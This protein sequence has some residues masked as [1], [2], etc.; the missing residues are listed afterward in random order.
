MCFFRHARP[1]SLGVL[2]SLPIASLSMHSSYAE[3]VWTQQFNDIL[4]EAKAGNADAQYEVGIM[5]LKGQGTDS[6]R[7][8]A[9]KWLSSSAAAGNADATAKL[10]RMDDQADKFHALMRNAKNGDPESQYDVAMMLLKGRG[11]EQDQ[12][13]GK[14][15][16]ARAA[17]QTNQKAITRL[18][19]LFYKGEQ[20]KQDYREAY[21]LFDQVKQESVLAQY[22]LGEMYANGEGVERSYSAAI[23]WYQKAADGG[24]KRALGKIINLQEERDMEQRRKHLVEQQVLPAAVP[25]TQTA[26]VTTPVL[27]LSKS[28]ARPART[29]NNSTQKKPPIRPLVSN[30]TLLAGNQW[31][32]EDEPVEFLPSQV[33]KCEMESDQLV[34]LS[35]TLRRNSGRKIV[36][37]R[38]KS[39]IS[40][41]QDGSLDIVYRNLVLDVLTEEDDTDDQPLGYDG[42]IEQ[43]FHVQTGWTKEHKVACK[44]KSGALLECVKDSAHKMRI[45]KG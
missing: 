27:A 37:Y 24:F 12:E 44:A 33:T 7:S 21:R 25:K 31:L 34:C 26:K 16:L 32:R 15:W 2:L 30:L 17:N 20:G 4:E 35:S 5:Y 14:M 38:V 43:G 19:I 40:S 9:V 13:Q 18:G 8:Q 36:E 6:D 22:Y 28:E 11:I 1:A 10:R 23:N 45:N 39:I 41:D 42:Q 3:D 29:E